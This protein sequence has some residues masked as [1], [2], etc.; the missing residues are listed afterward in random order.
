M[1]KLG[2]MLNDCITRAFEPTG[3]SYSAL[4]FH[5]SNR[6]TRA[7]ATLFPIFD[8]LSDAF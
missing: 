2:N 1:M 4:I 3:G 6:Q 7:L 8:I 5:Y